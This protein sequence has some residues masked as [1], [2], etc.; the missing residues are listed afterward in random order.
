VV[1]VSPGWVETEAAARLVERLAKAAGTE[2]ETEY[3]IDG[4]IIPTV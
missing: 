3:I 2:Y 4:G 1:R